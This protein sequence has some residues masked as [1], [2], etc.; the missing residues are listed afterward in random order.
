MDRNSEI[1]KAGVPTITYNRST[2]RDT[3]TNT[4]TFNLGDFVPFFVDTQ[5]QPG[6][7]YSIDTSIVTRLNSPKT[8]TMGNLDQD[9][10]WFSLP[11][12][13]VWEHAKEFWGENKTGAWAQTVE[14]TVPR[15]YVPNVESG[16]AVDTHHTLAHMGWPIHHGN[17]VGTA[18]AL[19]AIYEIWNYWFRDQTVTAPILYSHGDEDLTYTSDREHGGKMLKVCKHH[20]YFTSLLPEPQKGTAETIS[21]GT[22]APVIGNGN[23][24]GL[25]TNGT[26]LGSLGIASDTNAPNRTY[27]YTDSP[28]ILPSTLTGGPMSTTNKTALGVTTDPESS[29]LVT[30]LSQAIAATINAMRVDIAMQHIKEKDAIFGTRY[31]EL[32]EAHWGVQGGADILQIAEYLGGKRVPLEMQTVL[33]T[34]ATPTSGDGTQQGYTGAFSVTADAD[35]SFTKSFTVHSIL[36]G[37]MCVRQDHQYSQGLASQFSK[38]RKYDYYWN[39]LANIGYQPVYKKEIYTTGTST[40]DEVLGYKPPYQEYRTWVNITTGE[41]NPDY[42]QSLDYWTYADDY[43]SAPVYSTEF[44]EETPDFLDRTLFIPSTTA[45]NFLCDIACNIT[46]ISEVPQYGIPGLSRF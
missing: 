41:M 34:S 45:D 40:D 9:I 25:T 11:W 27:A 43:D 16:N 39:E 4:T 10:Y 24:L 31:G 26:N 6:D 18:I 30:D 17:Y 14:Y 29:G 19:R 37:V 33:Q 1:S 23:S 22:T 8:P 20:D 42:N 12:W 46:K 15:I 2:F 3:Y 28:V 13:V 35:K 32:T 5:V 21:L 44:L 36:I 7:T 38:F